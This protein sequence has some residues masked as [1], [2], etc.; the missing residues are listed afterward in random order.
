MCFTK[1]KQK[2][3]QKQKK[4]KQ[5]IYPEPPPPEFTVD[6]KVLCSG[7]YLL[8]PLTEIKINCAGCDKFFH[9]KIA[10]TCY[11]DNC[12]QKTNIGNNHKQVWC[13]YC[14]DKTKSENNEKKYRDEPCICN[15]CNY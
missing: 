13:I 7:C 5:K 15:Q 12:N 4:Y 1:K 14:V 11:G 2:Q 10:G 3:K 6:E 8:F 9:C